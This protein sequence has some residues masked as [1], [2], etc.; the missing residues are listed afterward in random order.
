[1]Y[2]SPRSDEPHQEGVRRRPKAFLLARHLRCQCRG[3]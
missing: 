1:V 2:G 3:T